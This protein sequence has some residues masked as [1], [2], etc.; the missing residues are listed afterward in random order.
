MSFAH[1]WVLTL[2]IAPVLLIWW[3][4]TRRGLPIVLPLEHSPA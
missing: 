1:P 3:E 4:W 2:L